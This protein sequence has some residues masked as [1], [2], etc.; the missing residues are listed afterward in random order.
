VRRG[1]GEDLRLVGGRAVELHQHIAGVRAGTDLFDAVELE[2][3]ALELVLVLARPRRQM[4]P[5]ATRKRVDDARRVLCLSR[6]GAHPL[7]ARDCR[8]LLCLPPDWPPGRCVRLLCRELLLCRR[9]L[10]APPLLE[11]LLRVPAPLDCAA[12]PAFAPRTAPRA[13]ATVTSPAFSTPANPYTAPRRK[14]SRARGDTAAAVAAA[15]T[16][17]SE[18]T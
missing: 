9:E 18:L 1:H 14:S 15:T 6:C 13:A 4:N 16:P 8:P 2:Q 10:L 11:L 3:P 7:R 17:V 12:T 5:D